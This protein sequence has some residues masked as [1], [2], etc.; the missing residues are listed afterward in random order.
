[1][2]LASLT[3]G[4]LALCLGLGACANSDL[5]SLQAASS[6]SMR[7]LPLWHALADA[8]AEVEP[9]ANP[10]TLEADTASLPDMLDTLPS[11]SVITLAPGQYGEIMPV[12]VEGLTLR[13]SEPPVVD[14]TPNPDGCYVRSIIPVRI[15]AL[16]V[17]D[18][19]F[20]GVATNYGGDYDYGLEI[21]IVESVRIANNL[22]QGTYNHDISTKEN[23]GLTEVIDNLFVRC[24][25]HC[26]EVGQNGNVASRPQ[27]SGTM[28]IRGNRFV[29]PVLHAITQRSN[30]L[31]IVEDNSFYDVGAQSI[32]NWP[33]WQ[34]YD[35]GQPGGP[36]ALML[37]EGPLRTIVRNND[38]EGSNSL[39]FEGRG[40][41]DDSVLIEANSGS[42]NCFRLPLAAETA[43][44]HEQVE[45]L[46]PPRLAP[47]TDVDCP[48][49]ELEAALEV[50]ALLSLLQFVGLLRPADV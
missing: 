27:Q 29:S 47:E 45:T 20:N 17:E 7:A 37:P 40:I 36:E 22:F 48:I 15:G 50:P 28:I 31:M 16:I 13:C 38:F 10:V 11:C 5:P 25:R 41:E 44:A 18:M 30:S 33:Y 46:Q 3:L 19:I 1:M 9:C 39:R 23:V 21:H 4:S 35:Y 2:K 32:Q 26:V 6:G 43:A 8:N 12:E 49:R 24:R 14:N 42:F 34:H